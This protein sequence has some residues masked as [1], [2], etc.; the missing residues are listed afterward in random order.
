MLQSGPIAVFGA[1][2]YYRGRGQLRA[3]GS[4]P[5]LGPF[6]E[7][8][9]K[10]FLHRT[11]RALLLS[12]ALT[13][14]WPVKTQSQRSALDSARAVLADAK[15]ARSKGTLESAFRMFADAATLFRQ[16]G[17]GNGEGEAFRF[18]AAMF[19]ARG[20]VDSAVLVAQRAAAI[21][22]MAGDTLG[23]GKSH[24]NL[25]GYWDRLGHRDSAA[26]NYRR[27]L[28]IF[29]QLGN[30]PFEV[31]VLLGL[32]DMYLDAGLPDSAASYYWPAVL[33]RQKTGD[34]SLEAQSLGKLGYLYSTLGRRDSALVLLS[35]AANVARAN[36]PALYGFLLTN[37]GLVLREVGRPDS[38]LA[39]CLTGSRV[40]REIGNTSGEA[41]SWY[42]AGNAYRDLAQDD[43]ALVLLHRARSVWA[44]IRNLKYGADAD[45]DIGV[46]H[47]MFGRPDSALVYLDAALLTRR[48]IGDRRGETESYLHLGQA[49]AA[50][51]NLDS[52]IAYS[53]RALVTA[54]ETRFRSLEAKILYSF[55]LTLE[56][57][58]E[59]DS[60]RRTL[61]EALAAS[62]EVQDRPS[63]AAILQAIGAIERRPGVG[64]LAR[65]SAYFDS[66]AAIRASL[67]SYA[68]TDESRVGLAEDGAR[69]YG[70]WAL[71]LLARHG[72]AGTS[73]A[74]L[75][76]LAAVERGRAQA[77]RQLMRPTDKQA[78]SDTPAS[79]V[80]SD[81]P[82][83]AEGR[84]LRDA[85]RISGVPVLYYQVTADTLLHWLIL[86]SGDVQV[87][88]VPIPQDSLSRLIG[89]VHAAYTA[90]GVRT[91]RD[92]EF[93]ANESADRGLGLG[94]N[95]ATSAEA[96]ERLS[97]LLIP[98]SVVRRL[99]AMPE[100]VVVPHGQLGLVPF[101][102]L[103]VRQFR[104]PLGTRIALR[105]VP[106]LTVLLETGRADRL[107][108]GASRG[109]P[110]VV[111]DPLMP[112]L[113]DPSGIRRPLP[114]LP[115]SKREA[116]EV[117]ALLQTRVFSGS[118]AS[119]TDVRWR[120]SNATIAHFATHGYAFSTSSRSRDSFIALA[121]V[122]N[123]DGLLTVGEVLDDLPRMRAE[124]VVLSACQ[125]GLG[126]TKESEG[127]LGFQ[128][129]FLAKGARSVLVSLWSVDDEAT[130]ALMASFYAHWV[131]DKD[132]PSKAEAL[133]RAQREI[134]RTPGFANPR[135][136]A[137]FQLI[138]DR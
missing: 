114:Q 19:S 6:R 34:A 110:L 111:G 109:T 135:F 119:E 79:A 92:L 1:E 16:A 136:W 63:E 108:P 117:A 115:G 70:D 61:E 65:A 112:T 21:G 78:A 105:Y 84:R 48:S 69:I 4:P 5:P 25:A 51:R 27:A 81:E 53:S 12:L 72:E 90:G 124:L 33:E 91:L 9:D 66:S 2:L 24:N 28:E 42:C 7:P 8:G 64:D 96:L 113:P 39:D 107:P 120:L 35:E 137:A 30:R 118:D 45:A 59:V 134:A 75:A 57:A 18:I 125:T 123:N 46:A 22:R 55:G 38:A 95:P 17:D 36:L 104:E 50:L 15:E 32:G 71:T 40:Q 74:P 126:I 101:A 58:G 60:A 129:A 99:A 130:R 103:P 131:S 73:R 122:G 128:R 47:L 56:I 76:A 41:Q 88:R 133:R 93:T 121:P 98:E 54:R 23:E 11:L 37:R 82:L 106:S 3:R 62:R 83:I 43:S 100:W 138:G 94:A 87:G 29:R 52:A 85:V 31:T 127:T 10:V 86:P 97:T 44:T 49:H 13:G 20:H 132:T 116:E 67:M 14:L 89:L 68:R 102:A 80:G 26:V 77:L